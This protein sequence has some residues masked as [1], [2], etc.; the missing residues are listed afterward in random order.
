MRMA[1]GLFLLILCFLGT[2]FFRRYDGTI[3]PY[4]VLW[5]LFFIILGI[6][7]G[8]LV[9]SSINKSTRNFERAVN[10]EVERLKTKAE[11]IQLDFDKCEFKSGSYSREVEDAN[12]SP[13]HLFAPTYLEDMDKKVTETVHQSYLIYTE[14]INGD[15][16]QF[17][18]QSFPID[19]TT[20]KY[21]VLNNS[22]ALYV[23]RFNR[24]KYVFEL[25]K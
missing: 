21:Y 14:I 11:R 3:I 20:L 15:T 22:I 17:I 2:I 7:G 1:F 19:L 10:A 16:C 23:D 6:I 24:K 4:P 5:Y 25:K 9:A 13:I 18:S 8:W 12:M